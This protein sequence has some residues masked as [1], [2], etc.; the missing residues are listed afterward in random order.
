[1]DD[2][3]ACRVVGRLKDM[4]KTGG[5]NVSPVEIEELLVGRPGVDRAASSV[6][7]T[8][9]GASWSWPSSSRRPDATPTRA[10]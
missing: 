9:A 4:I 10:S 3:G 8:S 1:M 7:R 5:E 6:C 2:D